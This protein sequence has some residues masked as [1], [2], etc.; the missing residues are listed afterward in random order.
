MPIDGDI[1]A[2]LPM[3]HI[4]KAR[5]DIIGERKAGCLATPVNMNTLHNRISRGLLLT[6]SITFIPHLRVIYSTAHLT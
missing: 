2:E 1:A 6:S 5:C 4:L 3:G